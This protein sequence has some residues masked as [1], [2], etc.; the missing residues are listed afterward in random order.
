MNTETENGLYRTSSTP[1]TGIVPNKLHESL[2][3]LNLCPTLYILM[4]NAVTVPAVESVFGR[5]MNK[6]CLVSETVLLRTS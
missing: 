4:Q 5:I 1:T 6:K 3:L 2:K